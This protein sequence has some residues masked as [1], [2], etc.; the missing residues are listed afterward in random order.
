MDKIVKHE[1]LEAE[2]H[3]EVRSVSK[4]RTWKHLTKDL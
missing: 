1:Y 3:Y 2:D 4:G